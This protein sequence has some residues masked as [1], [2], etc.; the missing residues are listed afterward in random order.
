M[1][2]A[3]HHPSGPSNETTPSFAGARRLRRVRLFALLVGLLGTALSLAVPFL[4]VTHDATSLR[5]PTA[6][7]T[8]DVSA[9]LVIYSPTRLH[10]EIPCE[11]ARS[12]DSRTTA[13]GHLIDTNPKESKYGNLTGL[14]VAV[15]DG[16]VSVHSRGQ[17]LGSR[18][19]PAGPCTVV[20]HSDAGRT[21]ATVDGVTLADVRGDQ[22]P[23]LTGIYSDLDGELDDVRGL[24][25]EAR[26]DNRF[27]SVATPLKLVAMGLAVLAFL[28]SV[29]ALRRLDAHAGRG[30]PKL[31]PR[32]WW[33]PRLKDVAV[34]GSLALWWLIG[35]FTS[36][37]GY[38]AA[39]AQ[40]RDDAGY[41]SNYY[42]WFANPEA[43][44]GWFYEFY[45]LWT[46]VSTSVPW[47]RL[48]ALLMGVASWLLISREVLPRL[49]QQVRRSSAA[50]WAAAAVFL[51]FWL[52]FNNGLRAEP[53][54]VLFSL[55]A[56]CAVER[57][58]ATA[59]LTPA[60]LGLLG[61]ALSL[62][63]APHGIVA[64]LPY[65]AAAKPL[66]ILVY[67]RATKFGWLPILSPIAASGFVVLVL[68]FS[69][70]TYQTVSDGLEL[71]TAF[72]PNEQWYE[73]LNRYTLLFGQ[74]PD[75]ALAR[76]FPVLLVILCLLT[77]AAVWL[78]RGRIRGA[79]L[80]P[81]QRLLAVTALSFVV[82]MLTRTKWSH[83]FGLFAAVGGALA[84]LTALAAG[85][86]VLRSRR[87]RAAFFSG[88]MIIAAL[89]SA[90]TNGFWYVS[91]WGVPWFDQPPS[92]QG[93]IAS[94][95]LL[96]VAA[97]AGLV[98]VFEHV[99]AQRRL[100]P[101]GLEKRSSTLARGTAPLA[102]VCAL[103]V[104]GE[105]AVFARAV[106]KQADSYSIGRDNALQ[107]AGQS[108]GMS[109]YVQV[110]TDPVAGVLPVSAGQP[111]NAAPGADVPER[112]RTESADAYLAERTEG[113][114]RDGYPEADGSQPGELDF[115]PRH[116]FGGD[117]APVWGSHLPGGVN[118]GE[119]RTPWYDLPERARTG[120]SPVVLGMAG[121][122]VA[123]SSLTIEFGRDTEQGFEILHSYPVRQ[124]PGPS[125]REHRVP[126]GGK[127]TQATKMRVVAVDDGLGG[128]NWLAV[129]APR[130][131]RLTTMTDLVGDSPVFIDW[132]AAF[133]HPCLR[134]TRLRDGVAEMPAF[135]V[136]AG[137]VLRDDGENWSAPQFGG[138]YGWMSVTSSVR[139][140]P[141]YLDGAVTR[142]WGSLFVVEPSAPDALPASAALH[143]E[144][145]TH[146]GTWSPGPVGRHVELPG[147]IPRSSESS[148]PPRSVGSEGG[149]GR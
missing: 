48:P 116:G 53:V 123:P 11:T 130:V 127:S 102:I 89:A 114:T 36:D 16:A 56:L 37:D 63:A 131:P 54:V 86:T 33:H 61:A 110:E 31:A 14:T 17:N 83:H 78:R 145:E 46:D 65:V 100:A 5:W 90:G 66:L 13:R 82:L 49:G 84:A 20:V 28:G 133:L 115:R 109:D 60:A 44:F 1:R 99:R 108:C 129:T 94:N 111:T 73:E 121:L 77:C 47:M 144:S 39:I 81:T 55:L 15:D 26:V 103:L 98:A 136:T 58:V 96:V 118:T 137:E 85:S 146:W 88:L 95:V 41:V 59:R 140:L 34:V 40:A 117:D 50:G 97:V 23:Q 25:V 147:K 51:A 91:S 92:F 107:L 72:G 35:A 135:R 79:A 128:G 125:W 6:E 24:S 105:L 148:A 75:G 21:N 27:D 134:T 120:D 113:F 30:A 76:R 4:P 132:V 52:P 143:V 38:T 64:V 138:P 74:S 112:L 141:T 67:R 70:Q 7:G 62:G 42:R 101:A 3:E 69:D 68:L 32:G 29:V 87:N 142:D 106:D 126:I 43:P 149:S 8:R 12:L 22:R 93:Y 80:G 9:P 71:K 19:L 57:A 18:P 45:A 119:L 2:Y 104:V 139:E 122:E 10:A 124:G